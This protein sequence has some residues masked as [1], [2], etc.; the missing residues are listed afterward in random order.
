MPSSSGQVETVPDAR[1]GGR[2]LSVPLAQSPV[3][4]VPSDVLRRSTSRK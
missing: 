2:T 4:S 3:T 1:S